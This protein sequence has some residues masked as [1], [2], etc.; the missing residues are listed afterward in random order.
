MTE[1]VS[2]AELRRLSGLSEEQL[3]LELGSLL[4][5]DPDAALRSGQQLDLVG[6]A[7]NWMDRNLDG[8]RDKICGNHEAFANNKELT[9]EIAT[10]ADLVVTL[11]FGVPAATVVAAILVHRGL[12]QLC[13]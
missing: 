11:A 10:V 2:S 9:V 7:N 3:L 13:Q 8:L 4:V 5:D 6:R 12:D 1:N